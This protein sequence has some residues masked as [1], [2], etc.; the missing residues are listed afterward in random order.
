MQTEIDKINMLLEQVIDPELGISIIDLG[1]VY[2]V[3]Y[4][5]DERL[6]MIKMTL[7]TEGCPMGDVIKDNIYEVLADAYP[8]FNIMIEIVWTPEW[9]VD[10]MSPAGRLKLGQL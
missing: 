1:L 2:D 5:R 10:K 6:I 8:F 3:N 4:N 7:T 9:S